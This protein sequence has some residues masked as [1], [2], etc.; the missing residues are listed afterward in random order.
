MLFKRVKKERDF[1]KENLTDKK[2][3]KLSTTD[4]SNDISPIKLND[5]EQLDNNFQM[6]MKKIVNENYEREKLRQQRS[7][8]HKNKVNNH[9]FP[10]FKYYELLDEN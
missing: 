7:Y 3:N 5:E 4:K 2:I 9:F 10:N 1:L 6:K 8:N